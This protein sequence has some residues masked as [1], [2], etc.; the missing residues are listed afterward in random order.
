MNYSAIVSIVKVRESA[1]RARLTH[2]LSRLF[3]PVVQPMI[4]REVAERFEDYLETVEILADPE[5]MESLRRADAQPDDEA[6]PYEDIRRELG[7]A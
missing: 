2:Y 4:E 1:V 7:L 5:A 6:R 3:E